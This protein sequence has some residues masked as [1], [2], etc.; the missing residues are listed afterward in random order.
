MTAWSCASGSPV[1]AGGARRHR[2]RLAAGARYRVAA[3]DALGEVESTKSV[4]DIYAPLAGEV[5]AR[6]EELSGTP[7]LINS[8]PYG[9]GWLVEIRISD[10]AALEGLLDAQGYASHVSAH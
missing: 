2:V 9:E 6:N 1:R 5:V 4:S 8:D 10:P 3:G 7:E